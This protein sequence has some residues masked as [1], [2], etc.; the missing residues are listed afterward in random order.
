MSPIPEVS[1]RQRERRALVLLFLAPALWTVNY[2]VARRAPG[3]IDPHLL[4]FGRWFTAGLIIA[5]VVPGELWTHRAHIVRDAWRYLVLGAL[6]MLVCGAW[7]YVGARTTEAM[8]ISLIYATSPVMIALFAAVWLHEPFTW[9]QAM[10]VA[11]ALAGVVNVVVK[12]DWLALAHVRW[13]VGDAWIVAATLS[14]T[15]YSLLLRKW[16]SPLGATARLA[17]IALGGSVV[18]LPFAVWEATQAAV[19]PWTL[20]SL[21]LVLL[22]ALIPGVGAYWVHAW[23]QKVLGASRVGTALYLGPLYSAVMAWAVLDESLGWHHLIGA[24][25]I[26]PGVWLVSRSVPAKVTPATSSAG[27]DPVTR[28]IS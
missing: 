10:G 12:S 2:Y 24:A 1:A 8:N 13:V 14:W 4:A 20:Q 3:V 17:C 22:A 16:T 6:G 23:T 9:R 27:A 11:L 7:V 15:A 28:S 19:S 26:L 21:W 5:A 18:L 25:L